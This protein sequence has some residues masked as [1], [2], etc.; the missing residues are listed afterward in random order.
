MSNFFAKINSQTVAAFSLENFAVCEMGV[1]SVGL[2]LPK[3]LIS[4]MKAGATESISVL[5]TR[6]RKGEIITF[7]YTELATEITGAPETPVEKAFE[8]DI[9]E[10]DQL[11]K[12]V[13][14]TSPDGL[15]T[16]AL[17]SIENH[18][19]FTFYWFSN[20]R[21]CIALLSNQDLKGSEQAIKQTVAPNSQFAIQFSID[22]NPN[23]I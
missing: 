5:R 18:L 16:T 6:V 7:G 17:A 3:L 9:E 14:I 2:E 1:L 11:T 23:A 8:P 19:Q 21:R 10:I 15:E 4:G 13:A 22:L 12:K 20:N